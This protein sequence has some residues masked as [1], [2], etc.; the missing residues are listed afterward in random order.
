[1]A[2]EKQQRD[3]EYQ[4]WFRDRTREIQEGVIAEYSA[5]EKRLTDRADIAELA[6]ENSR[7][8]FQRRVQALERVRDAKAEAEASAWAALNR[9]LAQGE[10]VLTKIRAE[11]PGLHFAL[12]MPGGLA[13][14][15]MAWEQE[16]RAAVERIK[17]GFGDELLASFHYP[18]GADYRTTLICRVVARLE[19]LRM[20]QATLTPNEPK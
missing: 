8:V 4:S 1:L 14:S 20:V 19:R 9:L 6:I 3:A 16:A 15:A 10:E 18:D 12:N 17:P 2:R 13:H 5:L 11:S 7:E